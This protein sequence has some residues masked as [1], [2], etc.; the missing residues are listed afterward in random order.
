MDKVLTYC[1]ILSILKQFEYDKTLMNFA[2]NEEIRFKIKEL[3][4]A[5]NRGEIF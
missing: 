4:K 1:I 2:D 3:R 5:A